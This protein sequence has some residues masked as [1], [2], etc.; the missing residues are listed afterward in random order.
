MDTTIFDRIEALT[1]AKCRAERQRDDLEHVLR[2]WLYADCAQTRIAAK[3][4]ARA[5][6]A[7]TKEKTD[8]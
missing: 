2:E 5:I 8:V 6:L 7:T 4:R 1:Y 3:D